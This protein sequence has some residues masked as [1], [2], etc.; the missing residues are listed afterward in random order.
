MHVST[1]RRVQKATA[2]RPNESWSADSV[3]AEVFHDRRIRLATLLGNSTRESLAIEALM[4][5]DGQWVVERLRR[6][7]EERGLPES[8]R[9][10]SRTGFVSRVLGQWANLNGVELNF[11]RP[12]KP[13]ENTFIESSNGR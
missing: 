5:I 6:E 2:R 1:C 13:T 10:G 12:G 4:S 7:A 8:I 9:V 3:S 11:I